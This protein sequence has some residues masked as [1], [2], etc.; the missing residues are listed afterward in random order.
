MANTSDPVRRLL[1]LGIY[2]N[3]IWHRLEVIDQ[4]GQFYGIPDMEQAGVVVD[5]KGK[6]RE[7]WRELERTL[8]GEIVEE[9]LDGLEKKMHGMLK[10]I[11]MIMEGKEV[12][13]ESM[14]EENLEEKE[15]V[16]I[17]DTVK[18]DGNNTIGKETVEEKNTVEKKVI[19]RGDTVGKEMESVKVQL[20]RNKL[21]KAIIRMEEDE[22]INNWK[23]MKETQ[24]RRLLSLLF[25]CKKEKSKLTIRYNEFTEGWRQLIRQQKIGSNF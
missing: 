15:S 18:S 2:V 12:A 14:R 4:L 6:L 11:V 22:M 24:Q 16:G 20:H 10:Q 13:E 3:E 17:K 23:Q 5:P 8:S 21:A 7:K 1:D 19:V 25:G 9:E